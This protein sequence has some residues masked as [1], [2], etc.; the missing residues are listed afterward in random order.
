MRPPVIGELSPITLTLETCGFFTSLGLG[1][2][3]R[4]G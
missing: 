1:R 3:N 4:E 2:P